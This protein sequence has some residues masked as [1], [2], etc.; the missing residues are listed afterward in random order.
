MSQKKS[1]KHFPLV[2]CI[3][4]APFPLPPQG[5]GVS[6]SLGFHQA[7]MDVSF[8][9]WFHS[10]A[11]VVWEERDQTR[12]EPR[13]DQT[14]PVG[15]TGFLLCTLG[16]CFHV[17][18]NGS[19][20]RLKMKRAGEKRRS[21]RDSRAALLL[22]QLPVDTPSPRWWTFFVQVVMCAEPRQ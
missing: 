13:P 11:L 10:G 20:N 4:R 3:K 12:S 16:T 9:R 18:C 22:P 15:P 2:S 19:G 8:S 17:R 1:S 6:T 21:S 5:G 14:R 7:E